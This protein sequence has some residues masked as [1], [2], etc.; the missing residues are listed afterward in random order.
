[1][2]S[3]GQKSVI[4]DIEN[5]KS[6][7]RYK[8]IWNNSLNFMEG[9]IF[10]IIRLDLKPVDYVEDVEEGEET[11]TNLDRLTIQDVVGIARNMNDLSAST[12]M[13]GF[14]SRYIS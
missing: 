10:A 7:L 13:T 6:R 11:P 3:Q 4:F 1:M 8:P 12:T 9:W 2:S 5:D 14:S